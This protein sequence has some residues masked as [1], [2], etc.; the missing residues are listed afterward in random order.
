MKNVLLIVLLSLIG[1]ASQQPPEM[2]LPTSSC[3]IEVCAQG[4][5]C[6]YKI[7]GVN[8]DK[9]IVDYNEKNQSGKLLN[10]YINA[11]GRQE[12]NHKVKHNAGLSECNY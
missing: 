7:I 10:R 9:Y 11:Y 5:I 6:R 2:M 8:H 1:C 3:Y 4:V 12:F